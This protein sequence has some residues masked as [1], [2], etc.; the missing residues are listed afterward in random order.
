MVLEAIK[1]FWNEGGIFRVFFCVIALVV[2]G[3]ILTLTDYVTGSSQT[4]AASVLEKHYEPSRWQT[5]STV[6]S[7]GRAST[8]QHYYPERWIVLV[9][10]DD[11][12]ESVD[13]QSSTWA[14]LKA[15]DRVAVWVTHGG[16]IGGRYVG[17]ISHK[18][19]SEF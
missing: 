13:T 17:D 3:L 6:D 5:E 2:L 15:G 1:D 7:K 4:V 18:E 8:Y 16:I 12:A 10:I 14:N 11:D 9:K 19:T